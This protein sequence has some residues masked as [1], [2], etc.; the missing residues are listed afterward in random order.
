MSLSQIVPEKFYTSE[1]VSHFLSLSLRTVQ[2]LLSNHALS[3]YKIHGQYRVKGL[4]L[5]SYLDST[6]QDNAASP[7]QAQV[8]Y[9][10]FLNIH[11]LSLKFGADWLPF[12]ADSGQ[13]PSAFMERL[14]HFRKQ[15]IRQLGFILPDLRLENELELEPGVFEILLHGSPV[16]KSE[17]I[18]LETPETALDSV[19][20]QLEKTIHRHAH[21][22]L[23][24]DETAVMVE[25][26][27]ENRP[28]VVEEVM[29]TEAYPQGLSLGQLTQLLR[30]LLKERISIQNL[31]LILEGLA[32]ELSENSGPLMIAT[33]G[34]KLR[35]YL[36]RQINAPLANTDGIIEVLTF[37]Q[38]LEDDLEADFHLAAEQRNYQLLNAL[39]EQLKSA[40]SPCVIICKP[41]IR[42]YLFETL[43]RQ[44]PEASILSYL[45]IHPNY[46]VKPIGQL[47]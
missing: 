28:A 2:R 47:A 29:R 23:S 10:E 17:Q 43:Y 46:R 7:A 20:K 4:D 6:R 1:E 36:S 3:A 25:K 40:V 11:P 18:E 19:F 12:L 35:Q 41:I 14:P 39:R 42:R 30:Y 22:I 5:L 33:L 24:R 27:R 44:Y 32:D 34:E 38:K 15:L 31:G 26:I 45:E 9:T 16:F 37:S 21:E 13:A 8:T